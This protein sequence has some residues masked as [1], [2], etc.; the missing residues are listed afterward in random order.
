MNGR[1]TLGFYARLAVAPLLAAAVAVSSA[2]GYGHQDD[3]HD[4]H[5]DQR[6]N[7]HGNDHHD[8]HNNNGRGQDFHFQDNDRG[9][10]ASHYGS[11]VRRWQSRPQGR[12][13]FA[14]GQRI[15]PNYAIRPV[16]RSYYAG[17][18]PPPPGY[19]YGYY[20]GYVMAYDPTTRVVA[21][22]LDLVGAAAGR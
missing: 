20:D 17:Q 19:Q 3:H 21:D 8:D 18:P 4:D 7:N 14:R 16:P 22:V 1:S 6:D 13:Q 9:R 11:D 5:R 15:P 2:Q 12:P 10:F